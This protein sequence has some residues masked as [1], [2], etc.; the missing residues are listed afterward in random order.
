MVV[1]P[2]ILKLHLGFYRNMVA[3]QSESHNTSYK[4]HILLRGLKPNLDFP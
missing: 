4:G 2:D 3:K 1:L